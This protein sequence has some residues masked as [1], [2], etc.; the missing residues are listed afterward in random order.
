MEALLQFPAV[1]GEGA[2]IGRGSL[3]FFMF[4]FLSCCSFAGDFRYSLGM[5][6]GLEGF[7]STR[8]DYV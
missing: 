2:S 3:M 4:L 8:R 1:L 7:L 6:L 5:M